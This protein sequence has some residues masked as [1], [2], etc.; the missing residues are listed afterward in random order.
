MNLNLYN[1]LESVLNES[2]DQ[3]VIVNAIDNKNVVRLK[4]TDNEAHATGSRTLEPYM[5]F[6]HKKSGN[7]LLL[8]YQWE[9]DTYRGKPA[10]KTL[11][12]HKINDGSWK[13]LENKHFVSEPKVRLASAPEYKNAHKYASSIIAMV[14]FNNK[15]NDNLYQP[16]LDLARK[17]TQAVKNNELPAVDLSKLNVMPKGPIKQKK[18]NIYTSKPNSKNYK[19]YQQ[20]VANTERDAKEREK[21]WADYEKAEKERQNQ[22]QQ[23]L[24]KDELEKYRGPI[25]DDDEYNDY[26]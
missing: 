15:D 11:D 25:R 1:I 18:N 26:E 19:Q 8:V 22:E 5:L 21:Y 24:N 9:G 4:Y 14:D 12:I 16:S 6:I 17:N 23:L 10:W 13:T 3:N 20:N 2:V 7:T